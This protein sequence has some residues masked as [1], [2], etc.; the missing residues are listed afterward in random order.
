[1]LSTIMLEMIHQSIFKDRLRENQ[2]EL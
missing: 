2:P 1:M